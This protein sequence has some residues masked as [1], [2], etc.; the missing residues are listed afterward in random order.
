MAGSWQPAN[1][2][3]RNASEAL[4]SAQPLS[5]SNKANNLIS[6]NCVN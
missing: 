6:A 4:A 5:L 2:S 3:W 1:H